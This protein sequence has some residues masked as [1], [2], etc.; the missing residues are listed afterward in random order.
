MN[1]KHK[2][3]EN[4]VAIFIK[5]LPDQLKNI[6]QFASNNAR[7]GN[8]SSKDKSLTDILMLTHALEK[9]FSLPNPR[10]SF[11]LKKAQA[12][13]GKVARYIDVYQWN[14]SLI[15]PM[16][17]LS[18]YIGYHRRN[19]VMNPEMTDFENKIN[20]LASYLSKELSLF[21]SAGTYDVTKGDLISNGRGDFKTLATNR[22]A[23]RNFSDIPVKKETI[24]KALDIAK[25]SP[26]ACNRQS[27]RVHVF[28]GEQ[29]DRLLK[30][31]GGANG[32]YETADS[33]LLI[34]ADANRYYTR[35]FHLGYVDASLFAMTLMYALTYLGIGS[36]PLT[37]GIKQS[38]LE[39]IKTEFSIPTNEI[40]VLLIAIGNYPDEFK[41]AKSYRNPVESFTTF[42]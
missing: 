4:S 3:A 21:N 39:E 30:M 36:I 19:N 35:E 6:W 20:R 13:L 33:V 5:M 32:F 14:D 11:G 38:V 31:Q 15:V 8:E 25:K 12:L 10:K 16:S 26:S 17:V 28:H 37:L 18:E 34:S 22:Y 23:I 27:Y 24:Y 40:P 29:K 2:I 42:H 1:I 41:V 9:A 7:C